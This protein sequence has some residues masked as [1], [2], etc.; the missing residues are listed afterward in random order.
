VE[1]VT[2]PGDP[3]PGVAAPAPVPVVP[4]GRLD[5][6]ARE[7]AEIRRRLEER[8]AEVRDL[9]VELKGARDELRLARREH[10]SLTASRSVRLSLAL[11]R[12]A[13]RA[14]GTLRRRA[15]AA[16]RA[17]GGPQ[18]DEPPRKRLRASWR[19]ARTLD[20]ALLAPPA[21]GLTAGPLVSIVVVNR[22]GADHLRRL[23]RA[24]RA[25]AYRPFEVILVDNA[26][27]DDSVRVFESASL[28]VP[29][30]VVRNAANES[31]SAANNRG[32]AVARGELVL[33]LNN[34]IR[35]ARPDWLG[36][37]VETL[38]SP[39]V[40]AVG[41]RLVY[42]RRPGPAWGPPQR[43]ADLE[44]QH[45]GIE[46]R[47]LGGMLLGANV[48]GVDPLS[49]VAT[50]IADVPAATAACLLV[51]RADFRAVGGLDE[52]YIY[53]QEDVDFCLRLRAAGLRTRY[54]GRA[55]LWH[56]ESATQHAEAVEDR[57]VRQVANRERF[58]GIWGPRLFRSVLVDRLT[59]SGEWSAA[60]LAVAVAVV[61]GTTPGPAAPADPEVLA[62]A[63]ALGG[64]GW[65]AE[66]VAD[67][68]DRD[69]DRD[70]DREANLD[71]ALVTSPEVDAHRLPGPVV[72]VAWVRDRPDAW[73]ARPWFNEYDLV[74]AADPSIVDA[75]AAGSTRVARLFRPDTGQASDG[76]PMAALAATLRDLLLTWA[77]HPRIGIAD[78]TL[79]WDVAGAW[80]DHPFARDLQRSLER[81][82]YPSSVHL[83][84]AWDGPR[85]ARE[86]V[87]IRLAGLGDLALHA[88][89]LNV[90][91]GISHP[92]RLTPELAAAHDLV[93]MASD[94]FAER[95]VAAGVPATPLHQATDPARFRP[96]A[97]GPSHELLYVAN[98]RPGRRIPR[99][100]LPT[101]H[102]FAVYGRRWTPELMEPRYV[103]D[104]GIPNAD[105]ARYYAAASIVLN[106]HADE[107]AEQGFISNRIYDALAA[108]T[109]VVTDAIEGIAAE[110]DG[111][112]VPYWDREQL[113][114]IV[115]RL[116]ADPAE[117]AARA[118]RG[119]AAVLAR[120][121]FDHRAGAILE[122]L[123]PMLR[124]RPAVIPQAEA[125][126]LRA[127]PGTAR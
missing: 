84:D 35:P 4:A 107:M 71:V 31:F 66:V 58:T 42:P 70:R 20:R 117:R 11:S 114:E 56:H 47:C 98:A 15:G 91:W 96:M 44:I 67:D 36:C 45:A 57:R 89:Q 104:T 69:R 33:L 124:S 52:G 92:E 24:L 7:N 100:L 76:S 23:L 111:G 40:G 26:S 77:M 9:R 95:L 43:G 85:R 3:E 60:P 55:V 2:D 38:R 34:D 39:G 64:L 116:L 13:R 123:E 102:E 32:V 5:D 10:A 65:Q 41:A 18:P 54:D 74:L 112:A 51:R 25:T 73:T 119:R 113:R 78:P 125:G 97:G 87:I 46:I 19:Q 106:D 62:L 90:L 53:G 14:I 21:A 29:R 103:V 93:Y 81:R 109:V 122:R 37:L 6:L 108:G 121:T 68:A 30:R 115:D 101:K 86:D 50:R 127:D 63:E 72:R 59:G 99:D 27:T 61:P 17:I 83:R 16:R 105:L 118:A 110:F 126:G 22:D 79:N 120:H 82:G 75:L 80:G 8:G 88:G 94:R 49:A 28:R 1:Q 12:R 48:R